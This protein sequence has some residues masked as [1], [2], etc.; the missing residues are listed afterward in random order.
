MVSA[1]MKYCRHCKAAVDLH[2]PTEP[3][4]TLPSRH[5]RAAEATKPSAKPP[6]VSPMPTARA[7]Y[8]DDNDAAAAATSAA[9]PVDSAEASGDGV[10]LAAPT[11]P[12]SWPPCESD[13]RSWK[14][15]LELSQPKN[16][17]KYTAKD[18]ADLSFRE[19]QPGDWALYQDLDGRRY[20]WNALTEE[21]FWRP[22]VGDEKRTAQQ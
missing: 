12:E 14:W 18:D 6:P 9:A 22:P 15:Q 3:M 20:W 13:Q 19:D 10:R 2:K 5:R 7:A 17:L 21:W 11:T 1:T 16:I 4:A 8:A